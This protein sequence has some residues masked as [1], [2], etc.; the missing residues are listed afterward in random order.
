M[1]C[2]DPSYKPLLGQIISDL[3]S[4]GLLE[5]SSSI[6]TATINT[7]IRNIV[8]SATKGDGLDLSLINPRKT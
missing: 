2:R 8:L 1:K 4:F 5:S 3:Q 6:H 7:S